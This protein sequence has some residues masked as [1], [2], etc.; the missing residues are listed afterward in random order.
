MWRQWN[1]KSTN[2]R[3]NRSALCFALTIA[4][5][6][7]LASC[8]PR[9]EP[10]FPVPV[11]LHSFS[12]DSLCSGSCSVIL[13]DSVVRSTD[14]LLAYYPFRSP[15]T[16]AFAP[17]SIGMLDGKTPI[18]VAQWPEAGP[19]A[20]T[21]LLSVYQVRRT[22]ADTNSERLFGLAV[23][24]P[25]RPLRTWRVLVARSGDGWRVLEKQVFYEP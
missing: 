4:A 15:I 10:A 12:V 24:A 7:G 13:V 14:H 18:G 20:D 8:A 6:V 3:P 19:V 22:A 5:T 25:N 2:A 16:F 9:T 11:I 23:V 21:L 1:G 17:S